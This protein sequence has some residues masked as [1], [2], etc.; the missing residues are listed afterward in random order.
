VITIFYVAL[1]WSVTISL[2]HDYHSF[3]LLAVI[4]ADPLRPRTLRLVANLSSVR[5]LVGEF[6]GQ[7]GRFISFSL[8]PN[9]IAAPNGTA[10]AVTSFHS[11]I[12]LDYGLSV[13][14]PASFLRLLHMDESSPFI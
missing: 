5:I 9:G 8:P 12:L 3:L 2:F 1:L 10:H 14:V 4:M 7:R 11:D 6:E 13:N